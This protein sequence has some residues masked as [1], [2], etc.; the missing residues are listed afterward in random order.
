M[1]TKRKIRKSDKHQTYS[2][3]IQAFSDIYMS[4]CSPESISCLELI[5]L[6]SRGFGK[7]FVSN[8]G[9][10]SVVLTIKGILL[11]QFSARFCVVLKV[12]P[13]STFLAHLSRRLR[14]DFLIQICPLSVV[15]VGVVVVVI[16]FS[17]FHLLFQKHWAKFKQ[18]WHKASLGEG[19]SS[20]FKWRA[21]PFSKGRSLWNSENILTKLKKSSSPEPLC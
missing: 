15:V 10:F 1:K 16:K 14:W 9:F 21:P 5:F 13:Y 8:D 12:C 20:L 6:L 3:H 7:C 11:E 19:E 2:Y 18:T 17:H 4:K